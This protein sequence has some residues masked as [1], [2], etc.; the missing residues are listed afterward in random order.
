MVMA[1]K[2][3]PF[4]A[5]SIIQISFQSNT[6]LNWEQLGII[7]SFNCFTTMLE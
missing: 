5:N 7:N 2:K 4:A 3:Q 6:S 1:C